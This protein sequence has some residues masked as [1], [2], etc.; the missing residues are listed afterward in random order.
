MI[1]NAC[2]TFCGAPMHNIG[3]HREAFRTIGRSQRKLSESAT[4]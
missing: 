3:K 1:D 2:S 4:A